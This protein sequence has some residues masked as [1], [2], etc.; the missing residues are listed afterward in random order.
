M[1]AGLLKPQETDGRRKNQRGRRQR[2]KAP[3]QGALHARL[4]LIVRREI[5]LRLKRGPHQQEGRYPQDQQ[6]DQDLVPRQ[7]FLHRDRARLYPGPDAV[8]RAA[9]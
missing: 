1:G 6:A 5:V 2:H 4:I 7:G 3:V 9:G 8:N